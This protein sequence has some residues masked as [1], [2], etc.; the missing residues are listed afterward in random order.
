V[1]RHPRNGGAN[2]LLDGGACVPRGFGLRRLDAALALRRSDARNRG[3]RRADDRRCVP[4][5]GNCEFARGPG[6]REKRRQAARSPKAG[7]THG[8][9]ILL[10]QWTHIQSQPSPPAVQR[11][12]PLTALLAALPALDDS[13]S[14]GNSVGILALLLPFPHLPGKAGVTIQTGG[15]TLTGLLASASKSP[16]SGSPAEMPPT[17]SPPE[18]LPRRRTASSGRHSLHPSASPSE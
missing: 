8:A 14:T 18:R 12:A 10:I 11:P 13:H 16:P 6:V 17:S 15:E 3:M 4:L 5:R 2:I 7:A 9:T 1:P